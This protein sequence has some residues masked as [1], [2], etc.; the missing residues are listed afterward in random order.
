MRFFVKS[1]NLI[2]K[3]E[4]FNE[5]FFLDLLLNNGIVKW[6]KYLDP[7]S[8]HL[9]GVSYIDFFKTNKI[10]FPSTP[11]TLEKYYNFFVLLVN[12][13]KLLTSF[14]IPNQIYFSALD[15]LETFQDFLK[16]N[17]F[18]VKKEKTIINDSE[19]W[20]NYIFPII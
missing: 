2:S 13:L 17:N 14:E 7:I 4:Q 18:I 9:F 19:V 20:Y 16:L 12:N 1:K 10:T 3:I 8:L 6:T 5:A 15:V 11:G